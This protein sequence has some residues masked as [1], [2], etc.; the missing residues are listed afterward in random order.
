MRVDPGG[1]RRWLFL[2]RFNGK[3][4]EM[5]LGPLSEMSL[6]EAREQAQEAKRAVRAGRNPIEERRR[7]RAAIVALPFGDLAKQVVTDLTPQWRNPKV[8]QQWLTTL[9]VDAASLGK[10]P[11]DQVSTEDVLGVLKPIWLVKGETARRLRSRIEWVLDVAKV[12]GM[13]QGENVARWKGHLSLLLPKQDR[14]RKHHA[15][16]PY[17]QIKGFIQ[18]LRRSESTSAQALDFTILTIARTIESSCAR[19]E[20]IDIDAAVWTV[21][22]ERVKTKKPYRIPLSKPALAI[23]KQRI[24]L[25]GSGF[26]FPG[27]V[28]GKPL[29]NMAMA[30]LLHILGYGEFTVHGYR[31]SFKTWAG[32]RTNFANEIVEQCMGHLVGDAAEQAY[33]RSDALE[34]RRQV[35]EAWADHC[36]PAR[37]AKVVGSITPQRAAYGA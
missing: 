17:G 13:R 23:A 30:R 27:L 29:S 11:V 19:V 28:R 14:Q 10:T 3:R 33:W 5:G 25:V 32:D 4:C 24:E 21:P 18:D 37:S 35:L 20:E 15:S 9:T 8:A 36:E 6:A 22:P 26:L 7:Q 16:M 31:A 34:R 2:F 12:K 1:A